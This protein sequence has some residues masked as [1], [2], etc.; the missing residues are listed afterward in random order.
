L[1]IEGATMKVIPVNNNSLIK[2][3]SLMAESFFT[4]LNI[5][6][7]VYIRFMQVSS[8]RYSLL[9]GC[10]LF[11]YA[12]QPQSLEKSSDGIYPLK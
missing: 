1:K 9:N 3:K 5:R 10:V 4:K 2:F 7:Y 6:K 11:P 8:V 12:R